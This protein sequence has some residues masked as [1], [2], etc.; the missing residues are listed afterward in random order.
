MMSS[1]TVCRSIKRWGAAVLVAIFGLSACVEPAASP[2]PT[3]FILPTWSAPE[4]SDKGAVVTP[5]FPIAATPEPPTPAIGVTFAPGAVN[6]L[7]SQ[8]FL[9]AHCALDMEFV[10]D[11]TIPDY[12]EIKPGAPFTK[13]WRIKNASSCDWGVGFV[14]ISVG[15][16]A[17]SDPGW[18]FVSPTPKGKTVDISVEM[19]APTAPGTYQGLW[20][21]Q[22]PDGRKFGA[23]PAYTIITVPGAS[24]ASSSSDPGP[25]IPS[26]VVSGVTAHSRQ[27]FLSGLKMGNRRNIFS[28]VGDSIT[29]TPTFLNDIGNGRAVW[30]SYTNLGPVSRYFSS[31]KARSGN[32]FNND[33]L[34][35]Y[36]G[37]TAADLT[38][39]A[40]ADGSCGGSAPIDCEYQNVKPA[41]AIIMIGTND[42]TGHTPLDVFQANLNRVV[43]VSI[44]KGVIPVLTTIPWNSYNSS[45]PYNNVI[46]ATARA[47]D[48]PLIDYFAA[49]EK[50][51]NHGVAGDGVHPTTPPDGNCANFSSESLQYGAT[52]RNLVTLQMLDALWRQV[53]SY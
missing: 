49:M 21:I 43:E 24:V 16:D 38:N 29:Y 28:K 40:K 12:T 48:V 3:L 35:A 50:A 5:A 30:G 45:D 34:S 1:R 53:L 10:A 18:V 4:P 26:P 22:A 42:A 33:S 7:W 44:E 39:P 25:Y 8:S 9:A 52:I 20:R 17:M 46:V 37:W 23:S 13:T 6:P 41:V 2:T 19:T 14:W 27:I 15:G 47:Y 31:E 32:S 51:P 36:A 11:V